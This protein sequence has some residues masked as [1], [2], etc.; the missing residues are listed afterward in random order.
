QVGEAMARAARA[1]ELGVR[2]FEQGRIESV[3]GG[4]VR[5]AELPGARIG[6]LLEV[7]RSGSAL[8]LG[9]GP[10]GVE[11]VAVDDRGLLEGAAV[12]AG[13]RV[14]ALP[15]SEALLSRVVDP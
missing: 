8:V 7:G 2:V 14:A 11:A 4:V 10:D 5:I 1:F 15:V 3:H 6:E 9:L 12:R 13:G